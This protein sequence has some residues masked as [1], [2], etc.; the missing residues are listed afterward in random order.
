M[1]RHLSH[2]RHWCAI[3]LQKGWFEKAQEQAA[4]AN[5]IELDIARAELNVVQNR[6]ARFDLAA[7]LKRERDEERNAPVAEVN[8]LRPAEPVQI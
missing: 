1:K 3:Y 5:S 2:A 6:N 8:R 4:Y 7:R